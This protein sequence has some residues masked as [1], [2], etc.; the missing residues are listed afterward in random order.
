M[1]KLDNSVLVNSLIVFFAVILLY[2][3]FSHL[4]RWFNTFREGIDETAANI[5]TYSDY[6]DNDPLVLAKKNEANIEFLKQRLDVL[7]KLPPIVTDLSNNVANLS[8]G[9][10]D[11]AQAQTDTLNASNDAALATSNSEIAATAD[12]GTT[13]ESMTNLSDSANSLRESLINNAKNGTNK[14]YDK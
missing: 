5:P 3:I 4:F 8:S 13:F 2:Q 14:I 6:N 12:T 10:T 9:I 11:V 7:E 1:L